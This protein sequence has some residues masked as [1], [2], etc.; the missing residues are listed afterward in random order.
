MFTVIQTKKNVSSIDQKTKYAKKKVF[1]FSL[2]V[3]SLA[4]ESKPC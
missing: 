2:I 4:Y 1:G 3:K